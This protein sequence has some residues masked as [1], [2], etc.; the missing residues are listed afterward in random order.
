LYIITYKTTGDIMLYSIIHDLEY[1]EECHRCGT[2]L[3]VGVRFLFNGEEIIVGRECAKHYG[4]TWTATVGPMAEDPTT[5]NQA[6]EIFRIKRADSKHG[7]PWPG[8]WDDCKLIKDA[9]GT[10]AWKKAMYYAYCHPSRES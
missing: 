2:P 6:I 1:K 8:G 5:F 7:Y 3:S 9:L 10:I 4:I